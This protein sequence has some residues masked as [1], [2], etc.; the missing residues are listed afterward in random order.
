MTN[1]IVKIN[2]IQKKTTP[3]AP[4]LNLTLLSNQINGVITANSGID[5]SVSTIDLSNGQL[6]HYGDSGTFLAA[7]TSKVITAE[8]FLKQVELGN[9]SL[10]ETINGSS[11]EHEIQQ[12]IVVSNDNAWDALNN[13]LGYNQLETYASQIG[14]P[15]FDSDANSLTSNDIAVALQK[16]YQG[17]LL[18]SNDTQLLL[19]YLS[20]ANYRQY[21]LPA[22]PSGYMVY[23]KVGFY[24]DYV[25]DAV[26][27]NKG[28]Q[29]IVL[30]IFTNGNGTYNWTLRAQLMQQIT[31]YVLAT[32]F[33]SSS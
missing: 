17:Q 26:I 28:N 20:E 11:A 29:T 6:E 33:T 2:P 15:D 18:N 10:T 13:E 32:Y 30:V 8:D 5:F 23:H 9:E 31:K 24:E 21:I 12:M 14:I 1:T 4:S 27:I 22:I 7:S 16:L 25:H 19:S 3:P